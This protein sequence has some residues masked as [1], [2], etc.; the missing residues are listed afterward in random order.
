MVSLCRLFAVPRVRSLLPL[1]LPFIRSYSNTH[2]Q[3]G[4]QSNS[5]SQRP[6][7]IF[8]RRHREL[9]ITF[10]TGNPVYFDTL[11]KLNGLIARLGLDSPAVPV[12]TAP[13]P[14]AQIA[15]L[16]LEEMEKVHNMTLT[17]AAFDSLRRKLTLLARVQ[18]MSCFIFI[19]SLM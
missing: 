7:D 4:T 14:T 19:K 5:Q 15:W 8:S 18:G 10:F 12:T 11:L 6:D 1:P 9:P 17:I 13:D 2:S 3:P 16:N